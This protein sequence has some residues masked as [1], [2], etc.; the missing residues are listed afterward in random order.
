MLVCAHASVLNAPQR[1]FIITSITRVILSCLSAVSR[2]VRPAEYEV[3]AHS[4]LCDAVDRVRG[5]VMSCE[6][7]RADGWTV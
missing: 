1:V 3:Y 5:E 2:Q 4:V 7:G 6:A